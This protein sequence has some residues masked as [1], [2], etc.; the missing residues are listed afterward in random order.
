MTFNPALPSSAPFDPLY[1]LQINSAGTGINL[2]SPAALISGA[3]SGVS[4]ID[5]QIGALVYTGSGFSARFG[6]EFDYTSLR[7]CLAKIINYQ[8]TAPTISL[9]SDVSTGPWEQG[10]A[11]TAINFSSSITK[12]SDPIS[13]VKFYEGATLLQD[14]TSGGAIPS[15]GT[16]TYAW[17][18]SIT[19]T[20]AFSSVAT[21]NGATGGPTSVTSSRTFSYVY[22]YYYGAGAA[23]LSGAAI[24]ALTKLVIGSTATVTEIITV[25][26]SQVFYFAYP[27]TIGNLTS[28]LDVN[29]FE[30]I[31]SWTKSTKS[32]TGLDTTSQ[33][34]TCYEFQNTPVAG[35][36]QY[37]FKR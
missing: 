22:P 7:D 1:V 27:A 30:T 6:G 15:G 11:I 16:S 13:D 35:A 5:T 8:Y 20:Q 18:G 24:A 19:T 2:I 21:D 25:S 36:Y 9:S 29:G 31:G 3:S 37:T 12:K 26:G 33:S 10:Y 34:Y 4:S 23:G 28:I 32:I 14:Q 17:S